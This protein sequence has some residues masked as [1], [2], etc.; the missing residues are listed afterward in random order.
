VLLFGAGFGLAGVQPIPV[1]ILAQ[2]FNGLLLPVAAAFLWLTMND[3]RLLGDHG[4]NTLLQNVLMGLIVAACVALGL[5]GLLAA[6][7]SALALLGG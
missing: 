2:A 1:I 4:V 7:R 5:R 3:R 6:A